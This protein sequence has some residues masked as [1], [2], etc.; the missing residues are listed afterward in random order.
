MTVTAFVVAEEPER[1]GPGRRLKPLAETV[2]MEHREWLVLLRVAFLASG[3]TY[4]D[5]CGK[6]FTSPTQLSRLL[7]GTEGYPGLERTLDLRNALQQTIDTL[8]ELDPSPVPNAVGIT[9]HRPTEN[10]RP[11][12]IQNLPA[13]EWFRKVWEAGAVAAKRPEH[14]I[15]DH[16]AEVDRKEALAAARRAEAERGR[17]IGDIGKSAFCILIA[18]LVSA[19]L[20][21]MFGLSTPEAKDQGGINN[22]M[23]QSSQCG[24]T[25]PGAT[26]DSGLAVTGPEYGQTTHHYLTFA[27][28]GKSELPQATLWVPFLD[29]QIFYADGSFTGQYAQAYRPLYV[30]CRKGSRLVIANSG[31]MTIP[32]RTGAPERPGD[33]VDECTPKRG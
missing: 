24:D 23:C 13:P 17:R 19:S 14:W 9:L 26:A 3:L 8:A 30:T 31:G 21:L 27:K 5:L 15:N 25:D 4:K 18:A 28:P 7:N 11:A 12:S 22:R 20:F 29:M 1:N 6:A 16:I 33:T 10:P 32:L 2:T